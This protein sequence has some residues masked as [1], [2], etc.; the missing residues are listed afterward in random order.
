MF[1]RLTA[2]ILTTG[3]LGVQNE[4][5][6]YA[7]L[8]LSG[9]GKSSI[10]LHIGETR[11][12]PIKYNQHGMCYFVQ[13]TGKLKVELIRHNPLADDELVNTSTGTI[14][15][16]N[17]KPNIEERLNVHLTYSLRIANVEGEMIKVSVVK[18]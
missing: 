2:T 18:S 14:H 5:T 6:A 12:L 9:A 3:N 11:T 17:T 13:S 8:P 7:P 10:E 4:V 15:A 1:P 16:L